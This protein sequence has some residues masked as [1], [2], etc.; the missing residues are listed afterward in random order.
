MTIKTLV[1]GRVPS[2]ALCDCGEPVPRGNRLFCGRS[3]AT[4]AV[5][6]K[7]CPEE[8]TRIALTGALAS[9]KA[10]EWE[11]RLIARIELLP[12]RRQQ[13]LAAFRYG[14]RSKQ[15]YLWRLRQRAS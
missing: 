7:Q 4:K 8:R 10:R 2:R 13:I 12:T 11:E 3:C 6:A 1:Y 15:A 9:M 14:R 5:R